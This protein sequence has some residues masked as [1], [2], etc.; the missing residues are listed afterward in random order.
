MN[1]NCDMVRPAIIIAIIAIGSAALV[2]YFFTLHLAAPIQPIPA[3]PTSPH[4]QRIEPTS[5]ELEQLANIKHFHYVVSFT[6]DG[7]QPAM[8]TIK[9]GETVRFFN[10]SS[11][12]LWI[13]S[14]G[15]GATIAYPS[16]SNTG[17]CE[18]NDFDSCQQIDPGHF[19]EFTFEYAGVWGYDNFL[20]ER[21][22]GIIRVIA[23]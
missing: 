21:D 16:G 15:R 8:L 10:A 11:K 6:A 18:Q 9:N 22:T 19:W 3:S 4:Q 13:A 12:P 7:F 20:N 1:Y 5:S 14:H 23:S 17:H 2:L